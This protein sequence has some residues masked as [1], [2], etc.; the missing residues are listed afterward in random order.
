M[1]DDLLRLLIGQACCFEAGIRWVCDKAAANGPLKPPPT[2][3]EC[4][5]AHY[6]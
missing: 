3:V 4:L 2:A 1:N 6:S 5:C